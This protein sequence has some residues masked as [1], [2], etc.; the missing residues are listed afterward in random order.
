MDLRDVKNQMKKKDMNIG[1]IYTEKG[2][3][4]SQRCKQISN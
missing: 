4:H 3:C 1:F 2:L